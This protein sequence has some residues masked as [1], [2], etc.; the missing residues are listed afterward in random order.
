MKEQAV[1]PDA[2]A[3]MQFMG[4]SASAP[5][6]PLLT[7]DLNAAVLRSLSCSGGSEPRA[8]CTKVAFCMAGCGSV[9]GQPWAGGVG[10]VAESAGQQGWLRAVRSEGR[11][12]SAC[13]VQHSAVSSL[14]RA[15]LVLS[16]HV[17]AHVPCPTGFWSLHGQSAPDSLPVCA[18]LNHSCVL[19]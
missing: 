1:Q 6:L 4:S 5:A 16:H 15:A 7:G 9:S 2:Q 14:D 8:M 10:R 13:L 19:V 11:C 12:V 3:G 18:R 17:H